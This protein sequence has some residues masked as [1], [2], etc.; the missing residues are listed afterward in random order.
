MFIRPVS[1][2]FRTWTVE[3]L[4]PAVSILGAE[5][6]REVKLR[7]VLLKLNEPNISIGAWHRQN[8]AHSTCKRPGLRNKDA[9]LIM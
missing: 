3:R 4:N 9:A 1:V 7:L 8:R 6:G 5:H 2:D